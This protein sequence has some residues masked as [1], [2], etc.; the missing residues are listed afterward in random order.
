MISSCSAPPPVAAPLAKDPERVRPAFV[1]LRELFEEM[2]SFKI[3]AEDFRHLSMGMS[4]DFEVAIQEGANIVRIG[5]AIF[6][7]R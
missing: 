5:T 6:G 7:G 3:G 4:Q 1:R 2:R